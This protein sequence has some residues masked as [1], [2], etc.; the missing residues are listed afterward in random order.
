[1][2]SCLVT[3]YS[4]SFDMKLAGREAFLITGVTTAVLK[5]SGTH[6]SMSMQLINFVIDRS[7]SLLSLTRNVGYGSNRQDFLGEFLIIFSLWTA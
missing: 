2:Y 7:M 3:T 6:H 1:M 5:P 4:T